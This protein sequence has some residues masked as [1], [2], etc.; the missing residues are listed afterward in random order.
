MTEVTVLAAIAI[1]WLLGVPVAIV[2]AAITI[3]WL[4]GV[5]VAMVLDRRKMREYGLR[6]DWTTTL[7]FSLVWPIALAILLEGK[8]DR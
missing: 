7:A 2:L 1:V 6:G 5:P 8:A 4:L 3:V